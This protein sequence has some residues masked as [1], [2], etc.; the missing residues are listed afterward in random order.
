MTGVSSSGWK[1]SP[2]HSPPSQGASSGHPSQTVKYTVRT[3][4]H[5]KVSR[6]SRPTP[7][8][9]PLT[10]HPRGRGPGLLPS[11]PRLFPGPGVVPLWLRQWELLS[12]IS[13][14]RRAFTGRSG[15]AFALGGVWGVVVLPF[16]EGSSQSLVLG[17]NSW[18]KET[19]SIINDCFMPLSS[20]LICYTVIIT[21]NPTLRSLVED[22]EPINT[23]KTAR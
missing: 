1:G 11:G 3:A 12:S 16:R 4:L 8:V 7:V 18:P 22:K 13:L 23:E 20:V 17:Y 9:T 5:S 19:M 15:E 21:E 6:H 10:T 2:F 14:P